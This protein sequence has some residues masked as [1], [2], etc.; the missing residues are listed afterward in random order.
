[1]ASE[2]DFGKLQAKKYAPKPGDLFLGEKIIPFRLLAHDPRNMEAYQEKWSTHSGTDPKWTFSE[3]EM[4]QDLFEHRFGKYPLLEMILVSIP[5]LAK[6]KIPK[7]VTPEDKEVR[8]VHRSNDYGVDYDSDDSYTYRYSNDSYMDKFDYDSDGYHTV[9]LSNNETEALIL[10]RPRDL[11][12]LEELRNFGSIGVKVL[13]NKC[14]S[15]W[16][17]IVANWNASAGSGVS[18]S[19]LW[20]SYLT[21]ASLTPPPAPAFLIDIHGPHLHSVAIIQPYRFGSLYKS[22]EI[23][24]GL[25]RHLSFQL[26]GLER[27]NAC[28][29]NR[30]TPFPLFDTDTCSAL[31]D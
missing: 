18:P 10:D 17:D 5:V 13:P 19:T 15:L 23:L 25:V 11:I 14:A 24:R 4:E 8:K 1:V 27:S 9:E 31:P 3:A 29:G 7:A 20:R 26:R 16:G 28:P 30:E 6:D 2:K 21:S 12:L 22:R